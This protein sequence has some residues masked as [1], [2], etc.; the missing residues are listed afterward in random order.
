MSRNWSVLSLQLWTLMLAVCF[1]LSETIQAQTFARL[2]PAKFTCGFQTGHVPLL[3][4]PQIAQSYEDFKAGNYATAINV[5]N[6]TLGSPQFWAYVALP[7]DR[8][9]IFFLG[10]FRL[11]LG[12]VT[13]IDC[14][15]IA[16]AAL[17]S[18]G[19]F[20][21][22]I[23]Y[24]YANNDSFKVDAIYTYSS[25]D[26]LE[27]HIVWGLH[28]PT[29]TFGALESLGAEHSP[30]VVADPDFPATQIAASGAGG[31]GLGAS[32]DLEEVRSRLLTPSIL[33]GDVD[34]RV[35]E[36]LADLPRGLPTAAN[37]EP[38]K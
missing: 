12:G 3:S 7:N 13:K 38:P 25:R 21:E 35:D 26:A 9:H 20:F 4:N 34:T 14:P 11:P 29:S 15:K 5:T 16:A 32:I 37:S 22:G 17:Q 24:I 36:T 8:H 30:L 2:Y 6:V 27:R 19:E 28:G 10:E 18:D 33:K 1:L 23:V 31:I